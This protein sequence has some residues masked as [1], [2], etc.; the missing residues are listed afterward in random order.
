MIVNCILQRSRRGLRS[1]Y[2]DVLNPGGSKPS[3]SGGGGPPPPSPP[4]MGAMMPG[5]PQPF[6]GT[7]FVP[8]QPPDGDEQS[9][10][11]NTAETPPTP[12]APD[13]TTNEIHTRV[14]TSESSGGSQH[15]PSTDMAGGVFQS[16]QP[17]GAPTPVQEQYLGQQGV[18]AWQQDQSSQGVHQALP[19]EAQRLATYSVTESI[20]D[21]FWC[22]M[23]VHVYTYLSEHFFDDHFHTYTPILAMPCP[24]GW[25][26]LLYSIHSIHLEYSCNKIF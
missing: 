12:L 22:C 21:V 7:F 17:V 2:V 14:A 10:S 26:R 24:V 11:G 3:G 6:T 1:K 9:G 25:S 13:N 4:L 16:R 23:L 8:Q 18:S 19:Q 20:C 5:P 15:I